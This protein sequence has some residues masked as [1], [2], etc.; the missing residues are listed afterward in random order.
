[1]P[2]S[3][4]CATAMQEW[5]KLTGPKFSPYVFANPNKPGVHLKSVR[6][7]WERALKS[8]KLERRPIYNL[9]ATFASRLSAAGAPDNLVAGMLGHSSPSIVSTYAKVVDQFRRQAIQM[10]ETLR[11][12]QPSN[13]KEANNLPSVSPRGNT[14][15]IN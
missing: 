6:K 15:W 8:A 5:A 4:H 14:S 1:M 7:T 2:M 12:S 9:R 11:D 3:K 10:L 13:G